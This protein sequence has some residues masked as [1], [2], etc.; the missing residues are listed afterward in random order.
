[1]KMKTMLIL[2]IIQIMITMEMTLNHKAIQ[3][4]LRNKITTIKKVYLIVSEKNKKFH[5][6]SKCLKKI[7]LKSNNY[8]K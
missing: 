6:F 8:N 7:F 4:I 5:K 1:M 2:L 3:I